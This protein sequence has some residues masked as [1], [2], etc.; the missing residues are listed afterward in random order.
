MTLDKLSLNLA[1]VREQFDLRQAVEACGRHGISAI[2][3]WRDQVQK[4][5]IAEAARIIRDHGMRVTGYCRGG[6]FPAADASGRRAAID[7]NKR[8][9]D[10]AAAIGAECLVLVVGGLPQGSR[11]I[12]GARAMVSEGIDACRPHAA[13]VGVPLAIEPLHPMYA[14]DRA[15]VNTLGQALDMCE[16]L[17]PDVGV[18]I[19]VYHLWWDPDFQAE[20]AR[21]GRDHRILAYHICDWLVPTTDMLLDRGMMGD[22]V[23]DLRR[24]RRAIEAAGYRGPQEVEILSTRWW[25]CPGDEVIRTCI[26]R[27]H[28]HCQ[29]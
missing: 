8:A 7:D 11:D 26:Q 20:I 23:I 3:P 28:E 21:A 5:G 19:D 27:F 22:G 18:A 24:I 13:A 10:E 2:D 4:Q 14:A 16:Q 6:F 9:L 12:A 15:C 17:G 29:L 1:T 25:S